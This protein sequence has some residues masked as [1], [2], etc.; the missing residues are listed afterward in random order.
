MLGLSGLVVLAGLW[1][2]DKRLSRAGGRM[3]AAE[4]LAIAAKNFGKN[5]VNRTRPD[6]YLEDGHYKRKGGHSQEPRL[7]AFPS[8]HTAG[9]F[10]VARAF[11]REYPEHTGAALGAAVAIGGL[12]LLR[13]AHWPSDIVA[14]AGV[15]L[16][17]EA[18]TNQAA[19]LLEDDGT[20]T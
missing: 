7:R 17:A 2:G 5:R 18:I 20:V 11:T 12:Q 6:E 15:G 3:L 14:G 10:A 1:R 13:R 9:S 8:G 4:C 16:A 19:R